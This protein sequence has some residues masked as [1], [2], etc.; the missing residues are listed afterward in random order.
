MQAHAAK[1][2]RTPPM[3]A[4]SALFADSIT[5]ALRIKNEVEVGEPL[6]A[7]G[8]DSRAA[9]EIGGWTG[10]TPEA[11]NSALDV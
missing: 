3:A 4:T 7:Y 10:S 1:I 5:R 2:P 8:L 11:E 6:V 9:V